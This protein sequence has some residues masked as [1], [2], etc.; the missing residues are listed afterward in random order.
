MRCS[1]WNTWFAI[2][3]EN[4]AAR[5]LCQSE[6]GGVR[7]EAGGRQPDYVATVRQ[8]SGGFGSGIEG[9][10]IEKVDY[11]GGCPRSLS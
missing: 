11:L 3:R 10:S 2:R 4:P 6:Q 9:P 5:R 8:F 1:S 7:G